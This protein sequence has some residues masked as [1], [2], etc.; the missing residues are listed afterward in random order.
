ML[1]L[2]EQKERLNNL[3]EKINYVKLRRTFREYLECAIEKQKCYE[4]SLKFIIVIDGI[5]ECYGCADN[6]FYV[7][8]LL[9][10]ESGYRDIHFVILSI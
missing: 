3:K 2:D 4:H 9:G 10:E 6:D 5:D 7:G 1:V 8:E